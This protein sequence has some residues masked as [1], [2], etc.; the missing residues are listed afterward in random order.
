MNIDYYQENSYA[1]VSDE[2]GNLKVVHKNNDKCQFQD[3]LQK[4]NNYS[5][6]K[7]ENLELQRKLKKYENKKYKLDRTMHVTLPICFYVS[8][9]S[10]CAIMHVIPFSIF[11]LLSSSYLSSIIMINNKIKKLT[12]NIGSIKIDI[13]SKENEKEELEKEIK[14]L[15]ESVGYKEIKHENRISTADYKPICDIYNM[16]TVEEEKESP[17]VKIIRFGNDQNKK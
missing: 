16:S 2:N 8:Y 12:D 15:K 7:N 3:I 9:F 10:I 17:K 5:N 6:L 14:D 13:I 11:M 4:E 1:I